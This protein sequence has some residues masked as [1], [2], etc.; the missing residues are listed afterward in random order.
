[1]R[2]MLWLLVAAC[3]ALGGCGA[4]WDSYE[5]RPSGSES[6]TS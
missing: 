1:M 3:L 5:L 6:G 2:R 4:F